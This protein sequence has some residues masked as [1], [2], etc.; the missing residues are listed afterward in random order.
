[1]R[2]LIIGGTGFLGYHATRELSERGHDVT[3]VGLR[4][5]R[6]YRTAGASKGIRS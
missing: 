2:V 6:G 3:A 1:M 5:L 4:S